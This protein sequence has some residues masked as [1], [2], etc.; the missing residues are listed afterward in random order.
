LI[1]IKLLSDECSNSDLLLLSDY[2]KITVK[3]P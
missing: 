3:L 1:F 2:C